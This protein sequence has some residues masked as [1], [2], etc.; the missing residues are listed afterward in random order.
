MKP[1]R[2]READASAW[3]LDFVTAR[4]LDECC[5]IL[6]R[7]STRLSPGKQQAW[8]ETDASFTVKRFLSLSDTRKYQL[9][10]C[11]EG[12]LNSVSNGTHVQGQITTNTRKLVRRAQWVPYASVGTFI[13]CVGVVWL[14]SMEMFATLLAMIFAVLMAVFVFLTAHDI[15]DRVA[16]LPSWIHTELYLPVD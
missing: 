7:E 3:Q 4:S 15:P 8:V 5:D 6:V 10:I 13:L 2:K 14:I 12:V 9:N 11:F 16:E 1:K